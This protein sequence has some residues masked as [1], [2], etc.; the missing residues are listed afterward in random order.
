MFQ[1]HR[2]PGKYQRWNP[3]AKIIKLLAC[4]LNQ[5]VSSSGKTEK[6]SLLGNSRAAMS[7]PNLVEVEHVHRPKSKN[8]VHLTTIIISL[9]KAKDAKSWIS[10]CR[11]FSFHVTCSGQI[12]VVR[13]NKENYV[14]GKMFKQNAV[15]CHS[16]QHVI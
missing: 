8:L 4:P 5:I 14:N 15:T 2:Y 10:K 1:R 13:A 12:H 3:Q 6:R 9:D 7:C 16:S 11:S